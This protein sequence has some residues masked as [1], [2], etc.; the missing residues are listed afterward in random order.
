MS[1]TE[2]ISQ[3]Q[4]NLR[5]RQTEWEL[6]LKNLIKLERE[7]LQMPSRLLILEIVKKE[8]KDYLDLKFKNISPKNIE[9]VQENDSIE[10]RLEKGIFKDINIKELIKICFQKEEI[11][12][13]IISINKYEDFR[14]LLTTENIKEILPG[15]DEIEKGI[16]IYNEYYPS[17]NNNYKILSIKFNIL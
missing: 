12:A 16:K 14:D 1:G 8:L 15:I 9:G 17:N 4:K 5:K 3:I 10:G 11:L 2:L 6:Q 7:L 13:Q